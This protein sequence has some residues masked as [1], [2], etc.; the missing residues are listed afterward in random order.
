MSKV[1]L[2]KIRALTFYKGEQT[3]YRRTSP[4]QQLSCIGKPCSL[5]EPE[6][7]RCESLGGT[8][9]E[10]DWKVRYLFGFGPWWTP[11]SS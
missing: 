10:V 7:V 3:A 8:G 5:F 4:L 2:A 11:P 6:V 9:V 1:E